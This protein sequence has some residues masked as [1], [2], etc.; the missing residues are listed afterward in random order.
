MS[1]PATIVDIANNTRFSTSYI[2]AQIKQL[3]TF[4][5]IEKVDSRQP[6]LYRLSADNPYV[7]LKDRLDKY[8][9][10]LADHNQPTE[11]SFVKL[12]RL[13]DKEDWPDIADELRAIVE[14]IDQLEV[15]GKLINTLEGLLK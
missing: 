10:L 9:E 13:A 3:E 1:E 15:E 7:L 11:N 6:Y 5:R 12:L 2:R 8:G 4:K 14:V